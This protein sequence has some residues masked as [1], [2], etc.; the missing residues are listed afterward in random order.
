MYAVVAERYPQHLPVAHSLLKHLDAESS[1]S[2]RLDE[3]VAAADKLVSLIDTAALAMHFGTNVDADDAKAEKTRKDNEKNRAV[4]ID[5]YSRKARAIGAQLDAQPAVNSESTP[6]GTTGTEPTAE[7]AVAATATDDGDLAASFTAAVAELKKWQ[8]DKKTP[9]VLVEEHLRSKRY[10]QVLKV[11]TTALEE[12]PSPEEYT[13]LLTMR[14]DAL[15]KLGYSHAAQQ[16]RQWQA[17]DLPKT[18]PLY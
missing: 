2:S 1:R 6:A 7:I 3:I 14:V 10:A 9:K 4:L 16:H 5:A 13:A 15:E 11:T 12:N 18:F 8:Q 17:I